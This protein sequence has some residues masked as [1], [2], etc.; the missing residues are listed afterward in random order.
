MKQENYSVNIHHDSRYPKVG[1]ALCPIQICLN[2]SGLQFK[3][4][5]KLYSTKEDFEKAM[6]GKGGNV[7]VKQLR[8]EINKYRQKAIEILDILPNPTRETFQRLFKSEVDLKKGKTDLTILFDEYIEVLIH[9]DRLKSAQI[10]AHSLISFKKYRTKLFLEEI[11]ESFLRGYQQ[12]MINQGNSN[13]TV[14]IYLRNLRAVYNKAIKDGYISRK[15]YPFIN[16]TIGT[17]V[18]SKHVLYPEQVKAFFDYV[19][20]TMREHRA[21]DMWIFCYLMNGVNAKDI[22]YLQNKSIQGDY[23][24]FKREKTKRTK[25]NSDSEIRAYMHPEMK[26]IITDYGNKSKEPD[27][28]VFPFLNG[29]KTAIAKENRRKMLQGQMNDKLKVIGKRLGFTTNLVLNLARH[30]FS[31]SLKLSETPATYIKDALGHSSLAV[32]EHYLKSIPDKKMKEISETLLD[33]K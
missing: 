12:W 21:K 14:Q 17:S 31:T 6:A 8:E 24:I 30:S 16:Y 18:K 22:F 33:F 9:E 11:N 25:R 15:Y 10:I 20:K 32:T 23:I 4:G 1:T 19:P 5:L 26:R 2:L 7:D 3:I 13:T 29:Y 28:Y 27:D